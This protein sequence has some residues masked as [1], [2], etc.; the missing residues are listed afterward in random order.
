MWSSRW[1]L[2]I[3]AR[4]FPNILRIHCFQYSNLPSGCVKMWSSRWSLGI[5][6]QT[7]PNILRICCVQYSNL[8]SD[9]IK[10]WSSQWSLGIPAQTFP[11]VLHIHCV[12]YSLAIHS[13]RAYCDCDLVGTSCCW[14]CTDHPISFQSVQC[15]LSDMYA[16]T[17]IW[18]IQISLVV[19]WTLSAQWQ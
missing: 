4:T 17:I 5:P 12:Q 8:P 11:N 9:W 16:Q 7:F 19:H 2:G 3:P 18:Y 14:Q 13:L 6:A 10:M 1:S 15:T